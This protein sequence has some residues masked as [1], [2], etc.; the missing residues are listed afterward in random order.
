MPSD[1]EPPAAPESIRDAKG[2]LGARMEI[3]Y[4]PVTHQ[5]EFTRKFDLVQAR[6]NQSFDRFYRLIQG[7]LERAS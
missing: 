5:I 1:L 7:V 4:D 2:W 3:P 6:S